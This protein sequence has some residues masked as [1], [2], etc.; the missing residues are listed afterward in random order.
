MV[1]AVE[2]VARPREDRAVRRVEVFPQT[3]TVS[4]S[5]AVAAGAIPV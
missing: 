4:N 3:Y 2:Q 1:K 5:A